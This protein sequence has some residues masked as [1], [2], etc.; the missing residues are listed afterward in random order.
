M[1][2]LLETSTFA[3][4]VT[5]IET[6]EPV[7]GGEDGVANRA[8]KILASRTR[9]LKDQLD[10]LAVTLGNLYALRTGDYATLRARAT[11]KDDVGLGLVANYPP[12]N[13][14]SGG[15]T[16][17]VATAAAVQAALAS[18]VAP[19][20]DLGVGGSGDARTVTSSTGASALLPLA[21]AGAA[22]LMRAADKSKLDG[23]QAGAQANIA[24]NLGVG[25]GGDARTV[26]SST[27]AAAVLP[28]A[29]TGAAGLMRAADKA[30]LDGVQL[31]A[32][33]NGPRLWFVTS[34]ASAGIV[35]DGAAR[36]ILS[37]AIELPSPGWVAALATITQVW[38]DPVIQPADLTQSWTVNM[39]VNG[40][41]ISSAGGVLPGDT[42]TL[43][44]GI[45]IGGG[46]STVTIEWI[47]SATGQTRITVTDRNLVIIGDITS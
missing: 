38:S 3:P 42:V 13:D 20:T 16:S 31:G 24:T 41:T 8:P 28:L 23:V 14:A 32:Q 5:R 15:S 26:T 12:T 37:G 18:M 7:I 40:T 25:G 45:A 46:V 27:G 47:A 43:T 4:G 21:S 6:N 22:G 9:W 29:T 34:K 19:P 11:T 30:K 36:V 17:E 10:A 1:A 39:K 33:V 35:G 2:D 44:G